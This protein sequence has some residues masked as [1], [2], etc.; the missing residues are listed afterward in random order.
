MGRPFVVGLSAVL[1]GLLTAGSALADHAPVEASTLLVRAWGQAGTV[2]RLHASNA[3]ALADDVT[4]GSIPRTRVQAELKRGIGRFLG[5]VR[6]QAVLSH[7]HF[8]GWKLL[9]LFSARQDLHVQGIQAGDVLLR[10]NGASIERPEAFKAVWDGLYTADEL[11][12]EI[13]RGGQHT[14]LHYNI[15]N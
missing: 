5:D 14:K 1:S 11:V 6:V 9:S 4:I 13:E 12:L 7:G 15:V 10:V 2:E 8:V 3:D